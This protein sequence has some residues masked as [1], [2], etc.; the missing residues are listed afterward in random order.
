MWYAKSSFWL[1]SKMD[2]QSKNV[3]ESLS[4]NGHD[5][6]CA[7]AS[8]EHR[9]PDLKPTHHHH[10]AHL[11]CP[12]VTFRGCRSKWATPLVQVE[13]FRQLL[14]AG[15]SL[16]QLLWNHN[17]G[18]KHFLLLIIFPTPHCQS[19]MKGGFLFSFFH[20]SCTFLILMKNL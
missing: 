10:H 4:S 1:T 17:S 15:K 11:W 14:L 2:E 3:L 18:K 6:W 13:A 9:F 20:V 12:W 19:I 7:S 8:E 5:H 16:L